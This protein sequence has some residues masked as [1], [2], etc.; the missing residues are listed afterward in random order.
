MP[1]SVSRGEMLVILIKKKQKAISCRLIIRES[2][3]VADAEGSTC[4]NLRNG[5]FS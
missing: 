3:V 4:Q 5:V 2:S 1:S